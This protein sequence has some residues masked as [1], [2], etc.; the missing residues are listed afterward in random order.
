MTTIRTATRC[1]NCHRLSYYNVN[2]TD[3]LIFKAGGKPAAC[4]PYLT[5]QAR[6]ALQGGPC[7]ECQK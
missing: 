2:P 4:F 7:E 5:E 6:K 1:P 3:Y